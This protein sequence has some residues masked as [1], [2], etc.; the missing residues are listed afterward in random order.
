MK[1]M[2]GHA[3][4]AASI[5]LFA[6]AGRLAWLL[7]DGLGPDSTLTSGP[8]AWAAAAAGGWHLLLPAVVLAAAG[9]FLAR[10]PKRR[11]PLP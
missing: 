2:L 5:V 9:A 10:A 7:K 3:L 4:I 11:G 6:G 1:S 8:A